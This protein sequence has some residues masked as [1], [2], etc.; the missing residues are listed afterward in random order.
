MTA[1]TEK[2]TVDDVLLEESIEKRKWFISQQLKEDGSLP[3]DPK[4]QALVLKAIEGIEK[5]AISRKRIK[6]EDRT[7]ASQ[8]QV[9]SL[10][11]HVYK[12]VNANNNPFVV[13]VEAREVNPEQLGKIPTIPSHLALPTLVDGETAV[14]PRQLSYEEFT[15]DNTLPP[16]KEDE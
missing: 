2:K 1:M 11:A 14:N 3:D 4:Q 7:A 10:L 9:A 8:E 15:R 16:P 13:D 6:I 12:N 5:V